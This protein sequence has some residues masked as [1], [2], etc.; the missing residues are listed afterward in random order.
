MCSYAGCRERVNAQNSCYSVAIYKK[1][2]HRLR[3]PLTGLAPV[4]VCVFPTYS[5]KPCCWANLCK[6]GAVGR[7]S[8]M[9]LA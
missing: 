1:A 9:Y 6:D 2:E 5:S 7:V 8:M 4:K 3:A